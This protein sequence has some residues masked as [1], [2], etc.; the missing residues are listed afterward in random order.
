[1]IYLEKRTAGD[2]QLLRLLDVSVG[3]ILRKQLARFGQSRVSDDS[4]VDH[5]I[6]WLK[7]SIIRNEPWMFKYDEFERPK[8]LMK[9]SSIEAMRREADRAMRRWNSQTPLF[10]LKEGDEEVIY[11][12]KSGAKFVRLLT[13]SALDHESSALGHCIGNGAY[14]SELEEGDFWYVSLRDRTGRPHVTIE[15][16]Y[17]AMPRFIIQLQGKQNSLPSEKYHSDI[18]EFVD[19]F[20]VDPGNIANKLGYAVD[21]NGIWHHFG[22]LP[23]GLVVKSLQTNYFPLE[24]LPENLVVEGDLTVKSSNLKAMPKV[25][26]V[27]GMINLAFSGITQFEKPTNVP[28]SIDLSYTPVFKLS[29]GIKTKET[30]NLEGSSIQELPPEIDVGTEL[31]IT[32]T[33]IQRLP[34]DLKVGKRISM[35][36]TKILSIPRS[37]HDQVVISHGFQRMSSFQKPSGRPSEACL[38]LDL[39]ARLDLREDPRLWRRFTDWLYGSK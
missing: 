34:E 27:H 35:R 29:A 16:L 24:K 22:A 11:E 28:S 10:N 4:A 20:N 5:I 39:R 25:Y 36:S 26:E 14:D 7:S 32:S 6:D 9:F 38:A 3:R 31:N 2:S 30:L 21:H 37:V 19:A 17:Q 33:A 1:M 23:D 13:P 15:L 18:I 12:S 8:K